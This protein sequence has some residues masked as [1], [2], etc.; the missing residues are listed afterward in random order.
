V[1]Q[2]H[3]KPMDYYQAESYP[4]GE[5]K[6]NRHSKDDKQDMEPKKKINKVA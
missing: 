1:E 4:P 3:M 6:T 2:E 5:E